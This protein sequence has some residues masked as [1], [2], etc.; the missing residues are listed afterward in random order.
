MGPG[1]IKSFDYKTFFRRWSTQ[2]FISSIPMECDI[3][4]QALMSLAKGRLLAHCSLSD[5]EAN[6]SQFE[7]R[8]VGDPTPA[9]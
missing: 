8:L 3:C 9:P 7:R 2:P 4:C 5:A 1:A 6:G